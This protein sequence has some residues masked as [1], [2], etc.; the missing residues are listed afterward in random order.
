MSYVSELFG[1][2]GRINNKDKRRDKM[3]QTKLREREIKE[4]RKMD[5]Q[6]SKA[7][8]AQLTKDTQVTLKEERMMHHDTKQARADRRHIQNKA[9]RRQ[10][11]G[12]MTCEHGIWKC[13]ICFPEL[14]HGGV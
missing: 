10:E 2:N 1:S 12:A 3:E 13:K 5:L 4:Q 7:Q 11:Q 8:K 9:R 6:H 14:Y